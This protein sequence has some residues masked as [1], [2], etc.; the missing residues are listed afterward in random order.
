LI[1]LFCSWHKMAAFKFEM[2]KLSIISSTDSRTPVSPD[3]TD[4]GVQTWR[5]NDGT[6]CAYGYVASGLHWMHFPGLGSYCFSS[7]SDEVIAFAQPSTRLDWIWDTYYRSILP[8]ALQVVGKE[9][10][11]ASGIQTE[12]GTI[13]F[14]ATS[15]SGKSTIAYG[16]SRRGYRLW[17]DDAVVFE[18]SDRVVSTLLLPFRIR[19]RPAAAQYF[20]CSQTDSRSSTKDEV[21]SQVEVKA[22]PLA[23]IYLLER[24]GSSKIVEIQRIL[25]IR[26]F[27]AVLSHAYCFSL[28]DMERK[29]RMMHAYLAL[30]REVPVCTVRFSGGIEKLPQILDGIEQEIVHA[31][32]NTHEK[33]MGQSA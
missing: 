33:G 27:P 24:G 14:C 2:L 6:V 18:I 5:E 13:A 31:S 21:V 29:R 11:H 15:E 1:D 23:A 12:R 17:S 28:N 10:L 25:P 32:M 30:V 9:A 8:M 22:V 26:A 20:G 4:P 16:L 19:L 3:V 7:H